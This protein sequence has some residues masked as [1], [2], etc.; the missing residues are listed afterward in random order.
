MPGQM[1]QLTS[2]PTIPVEV[3]YIPIRA[4]RGKLIQMP[5]TLAGHGRV[6]SFSIES[7]WLVGKAFF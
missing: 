4:T 7:G 3:T 1:C 6:Q 2:L 5:L